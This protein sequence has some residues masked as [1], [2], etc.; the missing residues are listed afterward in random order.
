MMILVIFTQKDSCIQ[1]TNARKR[2]EWELQTA[3]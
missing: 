2:E 3:F 1:I